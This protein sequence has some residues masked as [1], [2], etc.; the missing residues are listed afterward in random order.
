MKCGASQVN[1]TPPAGVELSGYALRQQPSIGIHDDLYVRGLYLEQGDARLL[2]LHADL[3]GFQREQV[4]RL[5]RALAAELGLQERQLLFSATHA[6][7]GPATVRLRAAGTMD[8]GYLAA[9][10][11]YLTQAAREAVAQPVEV[12]LWFGEGVCHLGRDRRPPSPL[13]HADPALPVLAFR[14]ADGTY[15]AV[16]TNYAMHNV[17]LSHENRYISADVA[18]AAAR[19]IQDHLPGRPV[20]LFTNGGGGNINP[21][22]SSADF[23]VMEQFGQWLASIVVYTVETGAAAYPAAALASALAT[24]EL[25]LVVLTPAEVEREYQKG[26]AQGLPGSAFCDSVLRAYREWRDETL[27]LL[28][29]GRAPHSVPLDVQAVRLGP[30]SL[31]AVGAEVF[32]RLAAELRAAHGPHTYV[33]GYANGDIGYLPPAAVYAE[34]GYE[35]DMAYVFYGNFMVAAGG[36][37]QVRDRALELLR[38]L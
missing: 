22:A 8:A 26:I 18:G 28:A 30:V 37:E 13:S 38:G 17:G 7:S 5:R 11:R 15:T 20:V 29:A 36:Y 12:T 16:L 9:L 6:H 21:P 4:Q 1:I 31:V 2:W 35:V 10:D 27:A 25:P 14:Q 19:A 3:I 24:I 33:I 23:G 34:G 32:S